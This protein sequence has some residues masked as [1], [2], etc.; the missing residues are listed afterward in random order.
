MPESYFDRC[1]IQG[2]ELQI[3]YKA[4]DACIE[5]GLGGLAVCDEVLVTAEE[6]LLTCEGRMITDASELGAA[7]A[8][9]AVLTEQNADLRRQRNRAVGI[10]IAAV[11]VT[12]AI[13]GLTLAR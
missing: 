8:Q 1:L 13:G 2:R 9:A 3:V 7:L 12:A 5:K 4:L 10:S 11:A 6:A